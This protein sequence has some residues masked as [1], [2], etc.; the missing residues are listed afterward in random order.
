MFSRWHDSFDGFKLTTQRREIVLP[1]REPLALAA[2]AQTRG[3]RIRRGGWKRVGC[4]QVEPGENCGEPLCLLTLINSVPA[5]AAGIFGSAELLPSPRTSLRTP[6]PYARI[7]N[8][9]TW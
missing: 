5:L 9:S 8:Q 6:G 1:A 3:S 4:R 2:T 7:L